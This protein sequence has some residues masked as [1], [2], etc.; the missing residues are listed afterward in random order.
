MRLLR[1]RLRATPGSTPALAERGYRTIRHSFDMEI[2][3]A[4][5]AAGARVAADGLAVRPLEPGEEVRAYAAADEAFEDHWEHVRHPFDEWLHHMTRARDFDPSL[6]FLALDGD[7]VAAGVCLCRGDAPAG[8]R[9]GWV[10]TLGV[11]RPWRRR[12]SAARCSYTPSAELRARG[13][14]HA[15]LGVDAEN[16]TG[17]V[18]LYERAGMHVVSRFDTW[19]LV[20]G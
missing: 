2:A 13:L 12:A 9:I 7:E 15:G 1:A 8:E 6:W 10:D 19:E 14:R 18:R 16:P 3:L 20:L 5:G 17:A 4:A 11:R